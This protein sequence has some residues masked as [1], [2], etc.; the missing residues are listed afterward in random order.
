MKISRNWLNNYIV[1]KKSNNQLVDS[2]TQLGLEC[3]AVHTKLDFK[4]EGL[5]ESTIAMVVKEESGLP[6]EVA[7][8][9]FNR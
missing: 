2:F 1:S 7:V 5:S 8:S 4:A 9:L 3:T 6:V